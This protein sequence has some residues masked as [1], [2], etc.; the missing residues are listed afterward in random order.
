MSPSSELGPIDPQTRINGVPVA[1]WS[2]VESYNDLF[3]RAINETKNIEPYLQQ[4]NNY[5]ARIIKEY[6][7]A[8]ELSKDVAIRALRSG[9]MKGKSENE[10]LENISVFLTPEKTKS[11]GRS[12]LCDEAISCGLD[13]EIMPLDSN[14][15]QCAYELYVRTHNY[16]VTKVSKCIETK[17][18]ALSA[19]IISEMGT[20]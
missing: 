10:I 9:M 16:T 14:L 4:L 18:F 20:D 8:I 12:I 1:L 7:T 13:V 15:W 5:D 3:N 17:Q 11:L 2:I 19:S 6:E